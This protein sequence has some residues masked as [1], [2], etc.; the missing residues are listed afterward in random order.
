MSN[1]E[2]KRHVGEL[3]P[4][5]ANYFAALIEERMARVDALD[6]TNNLALMLLATRGVITPRPP[7][8]D[9]DEWKQS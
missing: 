6:M 9:G 4:I 7:Q 3:A 5:V 2:I 1:D 8:V